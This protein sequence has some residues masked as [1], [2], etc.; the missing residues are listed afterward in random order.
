MA[1]SPRLLSVALLLVVV[2]AAL[3]A[4]A[5]RADDTAGVA[6]IPQDAAFVSATL[7]VREQWER[8]AKSNAFASLK[9]LPAVQRAIDQ[10]EEQKL[11]PGSP[12]SM[13]ATFME[14][15]ENQQALELLE[16]MVSTDTF[17]YGE[18]SC[19]Q[20]VE[21]VQ[22]VQRAQQAANILQMARGGSDLDFDFEGLEAID[23]DDDDEDDEDDD[24]GA[25]APRRVRARPVQFAATATDD[26][27]ASRLVLQTLADNTDLIVVP[28]LVWGFKTTK[29]PAAESQLKRIEVLIKLFT[30][31]NPD[32]AKSLQRRKVGGGEVVTFTIDGSTLPWDDMTRDATEGLDGEALDKVL[33]RLRSLD[34][35]ISLGVVGDRVIFSIGDSADHLDKLATAA[36]KPGL[37]ATKPFEPLV[38]DKGRRLTA[39][40]YLSEALAKAIAP[41]AADIEQLAELADTIAAE[42]ELPE[43]AAEEARA[44]LERVAAGYKKR[45]PVPG[46]WMAYSFMSEQGYEGYAWDWSKNLP[47]DGSK[48]LDLLEHTGGAPLGAVVFRVKN[49]PAQFEDI[50][51]WGDMAWRFFAKYLLAKADGDARSK[52]SLAEKHFGPLVDKLV[53]TVR[54]KL[55]PALADGQI[56]L[57]LDAKSR[58]KRL[59]AEL[60]QAAD[61]LPLTEP[62]IV[63]GLDDP[64]L[65][66]E[67]MSDLFALN[68]ELVDAVRE[69]DPDAVPAD[70]RI[71]DPEKAK[72]DAGTI[73]S[74]AISKSGLDEQIKPALAVGEDVAVL[75]LVPKQ[76]SRLLADAKLETGS[77]LS[78]F[79]EPLAAAATLDVAGLVDSIQPWIVYLTRYGCVQQRDG[80]VG[81]DTVL[82]KDVEN[83][84]ATDALAQV[85]VVCEALKSLRV[86]VAEAA[87][88]GDATVTHWRNV[89]R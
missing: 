37:V 17:L 42:A 44:S 51:A 69:I 5:G 59:Q 64:K 74:W 77:Q 22:K 31:A 75:S 84:Q 6:I 55:L 10:I 80:S 87:V 43:G 54:T 46:P 13:L 20:F 15:P 3:L 41:S 12:L 88:K 33:D 16:D 2:P 23:T 65:F 7:R 35:V 86:A 66:R 53:G 68:D 56:G 52:V 63:L 78:K 71:K 76:A 72:V 70:Y 1:A 50:V 30:Q 18:Q 29:L 21:L 62:A 47:Y 85:S 11:Q 28:D 24:N 48:R 73:W 49:D 36:G 67:G 83:E 32:L 19:V 61:P 26:E 40:S 27:L 60:P 38:A 79:E 45:L 81:K 57:V 25:A 4:S 8:I 58:T 89:I 82:T 14:L 9:K 34:L 39:V